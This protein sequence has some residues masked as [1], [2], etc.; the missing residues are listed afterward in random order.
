MHLGILN[1]KTFPQVA[2]VLLKATTYSG[3]CD[4]LTYLAMMG[5]YEIMVTPFVA[6]KCGVIILLVPG[7]VL[8]SPGSFCS[9][10]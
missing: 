8:K 4:E 6:R 2:P 9:A 7:K 10:E 1:I 3:F 5:V